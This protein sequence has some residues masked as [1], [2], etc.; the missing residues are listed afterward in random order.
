M[1]HAEIM[2]LSA[3]HPEFNEASIMAQKTGLPHEVVIDNE[4]HIVMP[5]RA[6]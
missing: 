5:R 2:F 3:K 6:K 1:T 4:L